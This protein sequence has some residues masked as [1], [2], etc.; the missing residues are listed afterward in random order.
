MRPAAEDAKPVKIP[1]EQPE[2]LSDTRVTL[3]RT[4]R[5]RPVVTEEEPADEAGSP[6]AD[7]AET[8]ATPVKPLR[9]YTAGPENSD[10]SEDLPPE[11]PSRL[12][13]QTRVIPVFRTA[14]A[15]E[16]QPAPAVPVPEEQA[17]I[18]AEAE[19]ARRY[20]SADDYRYRTDSEDD[21]Y[22]DRGAH[23]LLWFALIALVL[24]VFLFGAFLV[25]L[26]KV[27]A[28]PADG[29]G[30]M[31]TLYNLRDKLSP[32][33][34]LLGIEEEKP[35]VE[36]FQTASG[37]VTQGSQVQF[38]ITTSRSVQKVRLTDATGKVLSASV[39]CPDS[40]TTWVVTLLADAPYSGS[41]C[42]E[43]CFNNT[44]YPSGNALPLQVI[45]PTP[46]PT[47]VP[48]TPAP[49]QYV[50]IP[51]TPVP[52][53]STAA[54][55]TMNFTAAPTEVPTPTPTPVPTPTP[56]PEPT[57]TPVPTPTPMPA[58]E[59]SAAADTDPAALKIT[60]TVYQDGKKVTSF[61]R[62]SPIRMLDPKDY[63]AYGKGVFAFRGT[64]FRQNAVSGTVDVKQQSMS[65]EWKFEL[66]S[67]RTSDNGTLYGVG[68][69]GQPAIVQWAQA[70]REKWMNI[71]E[72][73]RSVSA[74]KEVIFGAQDGNIYFLDLTDGTP[75]RDPIKLGYPIKSSVSVDPYG[76]P[77][78][79][80]GQ[81]I[82]RLPKGTGKIGYH[83]YSLLDGKELLFLDGRASNSQ[84]QYVN[85]GAFDSS[86][87][88]DRGTSTLIMG[89]ENGLVYTVSLDPLFNYRDSAGNLLDKAT[90]K[91]NSSSV[92]LK[93]KS[94][95]EAE[96]K[97]GIETSLAMYGQY[98]YT[99]DTHGILQCIDTDTMTAVWAADVGDNTDAALALDM[100]E[101][102]AVSLYTGNTAYARNKS[103]TPVTLRSLNALTGESNWTYTVSCA[104]NANQLS[105]L[106][107]SPLVGD[108]AIDDLVIFTVNMTDGGKKSRVIALNKQT[109][110]LVWEQVLDCNAVSSP[111]AVYN[112]EG[113]A[114]VIQ[115]GQDGVLRLMNGRTGAVL[116]TLDLGGEIQGSPAVYNDIL[117]IGTC[118]KNNSYMYG[119]RIN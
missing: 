21:E 36:T 4:I 87:L 76:Y 57:P 106:K 102:G 74:L 47:P 41:V 92:V 40:G 83:V 5:P 13:A 64:N 20:S 22:D 113:T 80:V 71:Y 101:N 35:V 93:T 98:L 75:T 11:V 111:V 39:T 50:A 119:I 26:P 89:G 31:G 48:I 30:I 94:G 110:K 108:N 72:A 14:P 118:S 91:L 86:A 42:A 6:A 38:Q 103:K 1:A 8:R 43:F 23:R 7:L 63:D 33:T 51:I 58:F 85:N 115:A 28:R 73:K 117:V 27:T 70:F 37:T 100:D 17:H 12:G 112:A 54:V 61:T 15:D 95:T 84:S 32:V 18:P 78:L 65:I 49:T 34:G 96:N 107:A 56:T 66:G 90:I 81:A 2:A 77:L 82:S 9:A 60:G 29:S 55:P 52:T 104:Y 99:A 16:A 44:W 67:L 109:G 45:A 105:G 19:N 79:A 59:A 62:K 69:T 25:F 46:V 114:W 53:Q 3:V 24:V 68:C 116:S 97:T 10:I 88:I